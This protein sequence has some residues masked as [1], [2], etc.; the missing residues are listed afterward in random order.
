M[1]RRGP[2]GG[3]APGKLKIRLNEIAYHAAVMGKES[4]VALVTR[5]TE[6]TTISEMTTPLSS[7]DRSRG[8]KH[9]E[10]PRCRR[11][12]GTQHSPETNSCEDTHP[13]AAQVGNQDQQ[14]EAQL[15]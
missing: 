15:R 9:P 1:S 5:L 14:T 4:L 2:A 8:E 13:R 11:K 12:R 3:A 10:G 7:G 6:R